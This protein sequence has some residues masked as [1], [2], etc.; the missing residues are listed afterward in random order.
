MHEVGI[1]TEWYYWFIPSTK[2]IYALCL[3]C[4]AGR[5]RVV[6]DHLLNRDTIQCA[7]ITALRIVLCDLCYFQYCNVIVT[8]MIILP[9]CSCHFIC[10]VILCNRHTLCSAPSNP[11]APP[12]A[13]RNHIVSA[14]NVEKI[15]EKLSS[16]VKLL[17]N[18]E[19]ASKEITKPS[20]T[21]GKVC[22]GSTNPFSSKCL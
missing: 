1:E 21:T 4:Y 10:D 9:I 3:I 8:G 17:S 2:V 18:V 12:N 19:Q 13:G 22:T 6:I 16:K 15:K 20:P 14:S 5:V 7:R 11:I